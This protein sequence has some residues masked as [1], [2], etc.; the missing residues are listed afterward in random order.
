MWRYQLTTR[1]EAEI[2]ERGLRAGKRVAEALAAQLEQSYSDFEAGMGDVR[3]NVQ[4][5]QAAFSDALA[6]VH[7]LTPAVQLFRPQVAREAKH[8]AVRARNGLIQ[9]RLRAEACELGRRVFNDDT[10]G[11]KRLVSG[12]VLQIQQVLE[13]LETVRRTLEKRAGSLESGSH[14]GADMVGAPDRSVLLYDVIPGRDFPARYAAYSDRRQQMRALALGEHSA[15]RL[16][17][18]VREDNKA[19]AMAARLSQQAGTLFPELDDQH[20]LEVLAEGAAEPH[21]RQERIKDSLRRV[22]PNLSTNIPIINR[23]GQARTYDYAVV[24]YPRSGDDALDAAFQQAA[25]EAVREAELVANLVPTAGP[26]NRIVITYMQHGIPLNARSFGQLERWRDAYEDLRPRNPYLDVDKRWS[27]HSGPGQRQRGDRREQIWTLGVAYG[28]LAK[29]GDFFYANIASALQRFDKSGATEREQ[30]EVDLTKTAA[31]IHASKDPLGWF[32]LIT[33]G[34]SAMDT[35]PV[36]EGGALGG[37]SRRDARDR[38]G[39]GRAAAMQAFLN[40]DGEDYADVADAIAAILEAYAEERGR[41][42]VRRELTWYRD[43]LEAAPKSSDLDAQ[44][45]TEVNQ[46]NALVETLDR[47][48]AFGLLTGKAG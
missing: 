42:N 30:H 47:D 19:E 4:T 7:A 39:Q 41:A 18:P 24:L 36:H 20:I 5:A 23:P 6:A 13:T 40:D 2:R 43:A 27:K 37:K 46:L 14:E 34:P 28:L 8:D 48:G 29:Q 25:E 26:N 32:A 3:A 33:H 44:Y 9:A 15:L 38:I 16:L 45:Q 17:E 21:A 12:L 1:V 35:I 10:L 11:V 31:A 22:L